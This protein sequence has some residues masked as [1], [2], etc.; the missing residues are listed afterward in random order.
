M[1]TADSIADSDEA[2][3]ARQEMVDKLVASGMI[4]SGDVE[5]AFRTV[6]REVFMP[7]GTDLAAAYNPDDAVA[8]KRDEHGRI[9]SSLSAPFIQAR[10]IEQAELAPGMSVLEIGSGGLNAAL[11]AEVVGPG[12]RV[13]SVD[14]DP[15]ITTNAGAAL[16]AA[17]YGGRVEVLLADA[18]HPVPD[19]DEVDAVIVTVGAWDIPP[20]WTGPL[21][22]DGR[23]V[24]PL[25][26]NN[27][28][29]SI[30]FGRVGDHL[31]S[32]SLE[33]CGF[34]PMQGD[35]EHH[36]RVFEL[37]DPRGGAVKLQFDVTP[38]DLS[39]LDGVLAK[40]RT[41]LRSGVDIPRGV[42]FADLH[43]WFASFLPGFCRVAAGEGTEL[44]E[45][46]RWFPF[47]TVA[48]DG[49]FAYLAIG[50]TLEGIG[51]EFLARGWGEG[52]AGPALVAQIQAW[53]DAGRPQP[54]SVAFWP[55][56]GDRDLPKGAVVL[57]KRHGLVTISWP[58]AP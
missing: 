58:A 12:G 8:A 7:E 52:D 18:E 27:V 43:L 17:G 5:R 45:E 2:S 30:A 55:N 20:A 36:E 46:R 9:I 47:G 22:P 15:D 35:G 32:T 57:E 34:V 54:D 56:G 21:A 25:R 11:I 38:K 37:P 14:I 26:M 16:D 50:P 6:P 29:R 40:P 31:E 13:V 49:S 4:T 1:T 39:P 51:D 42:S 3:R 23:L 44:A 10:M 48:D 41:E 24:V 19:L 53:A 33:V 28:T